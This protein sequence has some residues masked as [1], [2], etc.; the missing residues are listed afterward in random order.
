[1]EQTPEERYKERELAPYLTKLKLNL[2]YIKILPI[3][4]ILI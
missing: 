3:P 2:L 1:M 4:Y